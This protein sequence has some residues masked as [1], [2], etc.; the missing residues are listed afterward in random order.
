MASV[1]LWLRC[2]CDFGACVAS[3]TLNVSW[4]LMD[5]Q[6]KTH[7]VTEEKGRKAVNLWHHDGC[8][9]LPLSDCPM[10]CSRRGVCIKVSGAGGG[11]EGGDLRQGGVGGGA[12]GECLH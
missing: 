7:A 3:V 11:A 1:P 8:K 10:S 12:E 4:H 5:G 6:L 9:P 2:L